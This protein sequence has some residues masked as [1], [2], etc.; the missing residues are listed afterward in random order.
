MRKARRMVAPRA[1]PR[2]RARPLR[3]E[4]QRNLPGFLKISTSSLS[5]R[6]WTCLVRIWSWVTSSLLGSWTFLGMRVC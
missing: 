6:F 1:E 3:K 2:P 4:N 5:R